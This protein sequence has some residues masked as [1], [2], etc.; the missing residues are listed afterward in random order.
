M[1]KV[2]LARNKVVG[3]TTTV[4]NIEPLLSPLPRTEISLPLRDV[5][6]EAKLS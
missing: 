1:A 6:A 5:A 2:L 4:S 3:L